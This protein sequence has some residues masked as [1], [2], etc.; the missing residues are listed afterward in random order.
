MSSIVASSFN[1]TVGAT[2]QSFLDQAQGTT[3][4]TSIFGVLKNGSSAGGSNSILGALQSNGNGTSPAAATA[5]ALGSGGIKKTYHSVLQ[6]IGAD[7]DG[8]L[9]EHWNKNGT[10]PS[11]LVTLRSYGWIKL[12]GRQLD[13]TT[14][15][16]VGSYQFTPVGYAI[17]QRT[18]GAPASGSTGLTSSTLNGTSSATTGAASSQTAVIASTL[19]SL[20]FNSSSVAALAGS[21]TT[22]SAGSGSTLNLIA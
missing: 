10:E 20:G 13:P 15:T 7:P 12:T 17:Y 2:L 22:S 19:A 11:T 16:T 4:D 1:T 5:L 6:A 14:R 8:T 3:T 18:G 9:T 21:S